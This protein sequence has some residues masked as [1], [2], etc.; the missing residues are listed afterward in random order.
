MSRRINIA[1]L[2]GLL[3]INGAVIFTAG[4]SSYKG[5]THDIA[6]LGQQNAMLGAGMTQYVIEKSVANGVFGE[7]TVFSKYYE[8]IEGTD[9]PKYHTG[10]DLYFDMNL[11]VLQNAFL[12]ASSVGYAYG[13][14]TDGYIPVHTDPALSKLR[15]TDDAGKIKWIGGKRSKI[16]SD[17]TGRRYYEFSSPISALGRNW[18]E[19]RVG[20]P[21]SLVT[22]RIWARVLQSTFLVALLSTLLSA[23]ILAVVHRSLLPLA[24]LAKVT[25]EMGEGNLKVRSAYDADDELGQLTRSFNAMAERIEESHALLEKRVEERTAEL[26]IANDELQQSTDRANKMAEAA[27]VANRAKSEFLANMSHEI[28]TPLNG[29]IGMTELALETSLSLEQR[30]YLEAISTSADSLLGVISDILDFSK[31]EARQLQLESIDFGLSDS[32]ADTLHTLAVRSHAKGLELLYQVEPDVPCYLI[33]D[34]LRLRQVIINLVGNAI[35]FTDRG[36]ILVHAETVSKTDSHACLQFSVSDTGV[37]IPKDKQDLIFH[38]FAQADGS[39]T[40]KYGGTGLGLAISSQIV[41]LMGGKM[42][43]ESTPGEGSVFHFTA[44]LGI[45]QGRPK[46]VIHESSPDLTDLRVLIVDDN[47]TNRRILEQVLRN[48]H[49]DPTLVESGSE[50]LAALTG[51]NERGEPYSLVLLDA[52]MPEMDGFEVAEMIR[53]HRE[54]ADVKVMMLTSAGHPEDFARMRRIGVAAHLVKP[55]KQSELLDW[56]ITVISAAPAKPISPAQTSAVPAGPSTRPLRILLA[57]DNVVNQKVAASILAKRGHEVVVACNGKEALE[58][59]EKDVFDLVLM[60]VQMPELGG[61]EA[62]AKIREKEQR[63]GEHIPIIA[64]TAH[65]MKGDEERCLDAGMDGYIAKPIR[66]NDLMETIEKLLRH[67]G[68]TGSESRKAA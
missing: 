24:E 44:D 55:V 17:A 37:G 27:E 53:G 4:Y 51:A 21:V 8:P 33:G 45:Q 40:R 15:L 35:K 3:V 6:E 19:F 32:L 29:V 63:T 57:E 28:R 2:I 61:F 50:A 62:T 31:V 47:A 56:I 39:T 59:L 16:W 42:W 43:V 68:D 58:A 18:G 25:S 26:R 5:I 38:A 52:Q 13:I 22:C 10:Y 67:Q 12:D 34:P 20:V 65:A 9:P 11:G 49:M 30:E 60:D 46:V 14:T 36:E 1:L 41:E 64:M 23:Y 7:D 48:W 66:P 54:L